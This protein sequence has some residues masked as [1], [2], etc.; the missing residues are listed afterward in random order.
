MLYIQVVCLLTSSGGD[1]TNPK[2]LGLENQRNLADSLET[3]SY[4]EACQPNI[5]VGQWTM[6]N[7]FVIIFYLYSSKI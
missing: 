7:I 4:L 3:Y 5:Q 6:D 1:M 2:C